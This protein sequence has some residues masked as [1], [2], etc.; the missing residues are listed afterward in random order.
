MENEKRTTSFKIS[1]S[2]SDKLLLISR[3]KKTT[4]SDI[5]EDLVRDY[6]IIN[7][8]ELNEYVSKM[9]FNEST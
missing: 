7:K 1:E 8:N 4:M 3:M 2:L 6:V 5:I 9:N